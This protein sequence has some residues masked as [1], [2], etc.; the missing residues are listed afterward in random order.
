M[1]IK[2]NMDS[3][4]NRLTLTEM[5]SILAMTKF[6]GKNHFSCKMDER[7]SIM[8]EGWMIVGDVCARKLLPQSSDI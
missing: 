6:A 7:W 3:T 1:S 5:S 8:Y 2:L 4:N